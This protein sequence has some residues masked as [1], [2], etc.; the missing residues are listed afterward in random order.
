MKKLFAIICMTLL[1]IA[2][3][4]TINAVV[5][6]PPGSGVDV[7]ARLLM[8]RYDE[9]YGTTTVF[10]NRPGA[11]G[12]IG[13]NYFLETASTGPSLLF[14]STGHITGQKPSDFN[15]VVGLIET[16]RQSFV[17]AVRKDAPINNWDEYVKLAQNKPGEVTMGSGARGMM[18]P[19]FSDIEKQHNIKLNFVYYGGT[20]RGDLDVVNGSL[21]SFVA[22]ATVV[23]G[24]LLEDKLKIVGVSGSLPIAGIDANKNKLGNFF[25][26]QG[27]YVNADIDPQTKNMF[28]TRFNEILKSTWA[29]EKLGTNGIQLVGGSAD[30]YQ[31]I[32]S[33]LHNSY[34]RFQS[35]SQTEK[36]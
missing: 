18:E 35:R 1:S 3:A 2:H 21:F 12:A 28:N 26:H 7:Q 27:V 33:S 30:E 34:T 13:I 8:K 14:A 10:T 24:G 11:E 19:I 4:Q 20:T 32:L 25:L 6:M 23:L 16:A 9:L 31:K 15:R 36:K 22:P 29:K 5:T 17:L